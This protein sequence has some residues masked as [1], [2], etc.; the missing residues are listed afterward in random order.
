MYDQV[1]AFD[2]LYTA[3]LAARKGKRLQPAVAA[4][5]FNLESELIELREQLL[6]HTY[7]PG[8]YHSFYIHDPK[9]RLI[10]AA[11]FRDRV[12][13]HAVCQVIEPIFERRFIGDS[14]ANRAGKGTHHALDRCTQFL[15]RFKYVMP[16]DVV[17][18]FPSIDHAVLRRILARAIRDDET[19]ELIDVVLRSG[20]GVLADAYDMVWFP[21]DDLLAAARPRGL[22]IGN[23]TSQ[24][25]ANVYLNE[26]DQFAKRRLGIRGYVRYVDDVLFFA[27]DKAV[28]R[29]WHTC[30][31]PFLATLRLTVHHAQPQ[32]RPAVE[33]IPFL[34]FQVFSDHRRV[35]RRKVIHA[36][37]H[38]KSVRNQV[39]ANLLPLS[40]LRCAVQ[41]WIAHARHGDTR[42][43]RRAVLQQLVIHHVPA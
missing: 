22:P 7:Q 37:R 34:G 42:G 12:V 4:F 8:S 41:A 6:T 19:L 25:W 29:D 9:R 24:F 15:R 31:V 32:P 20:V 21:G 5:E 14:Y 40:A 35:K 23:L 10:S 16:L 3:Y 33:G 27:D 36:W 39:A 11:P 26:F 38:L 17:Q 13:H 1:C 28:L 43:L 2:N 18:F 30:A